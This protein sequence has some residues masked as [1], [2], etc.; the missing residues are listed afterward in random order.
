MRV[1]LLLQI[2]EGWTLVA[3]VAE[4]FSAGSQATAAAVAWLVEHGYV[5]MGDHIQPIARWLPERDFCELWAEHFDRPCP[6][7]TTG[8]TSTG[9][10]LVSL[11]VP[12]GNG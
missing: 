2:M 3:T 9:G 12:V 8:R 5:E 4:K 10:P 1:G 6:I 11:D 7:T